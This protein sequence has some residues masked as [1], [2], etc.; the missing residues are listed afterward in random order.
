MADD[1]RIVWSLSNSYGIW[2]P[3]NLK[4]WSSDGFSTDQWNSGRATDVLIRPDGNLVIAADNGGI[5]LSSSSGVGTVCVSDSWEDSAFS[6]LA[7][8]PDGDQ[9]IFAG[10]DGAALY[11]TDLS[12]PLPL[13]D[14][15]LL[16]SLR[17]HKDVGNVY[18][19]VVLQR[20]RVIALA[21]DGGVFWSRI[22]APS[23]DAFDWRL[24]SVEEG[25]TG[26]FLSLAQGPPLPGTQPRP[27]AEGPI[28]ET[29]MAGGLGGPSP[30]GL[31]WGMWDK[32][33]LLVLRRSHLFN[34]GADVTLITAAVS[35]SVVASFAQNRQIGY[36]ACVQAGSDVL[37]AIFKTTDGGKDWLA[38]DPKM[39]GFDKKKLF[40]DAFGTTQNGHNL[41][42]AVSN[43]D[44]D[45][46]A[47]GFRNGALS[48]DGARHWRKPGFDPTGAT[49][50][51]DHL[52]ADLTNFA[53]WGATPSDPIAHQGY[54]VTSDGGVA[55]V[56]W[57]DGAWFLESDRREDGKHGNF[58]AVV[59]DGSNLVLH[60]RHSGG[61]D[62]LVWQAETTITTRASGAA[63][64]IQSSFQTGD[65]AN[66]NL[67]LVVPEDSDL[68]HYWCA[69][70]DG[71][72]S[73]WVRQ[74]VI[75]GLATGPGCLIQSSFGTGPHGNFEVVALE[76]TDLV[77]YW[78]DSA[79]TSSPWNRA[80]TITS[81]ASGPGCLIQSNFGT[82][83]DGN[84]EVVVQEG[85]NLVHYWHDSSSPGSP[86]NGPFPIH[87]SDSAGCFFQ[88][89]YP[90][91]TDHGNFELVFRQ[92]DAL[93]HSFR[94]NNSGG[95]P[96]SAT[97]TI[98]QPGNRASGPGCVFQSNYG[99]SDDHGNLELLVPESASLVHYFRD[100]GSGG[101]PWVRAITVVDAAFT[102]RSA[103]NQKLA[104]ME[105]YTPFG[106]STVVD[107]ALVG[108][109]QDNGIVNS[110]AGIAGS[111]W[112]KLEGGDGIAGFFLAGHS[113]KIPAPLAAGL[114]AVHE[115]NDLDA[116]LTSIQG[117]KSSH[118]QA[119]QLILDNHGKGGSVIPLDL[120]KP[121]S[122]A[123]PDPS[124]GLRRGAGAAFRYA[125]VR[126]PQNF[127]KSLILA[128]LAAQGNDLYVLLVGQDHGAPRRGATLDMHWEYQTTL[129]GATTIEAVASEDGLT[130]IAGLTE[131]G[132]SG[133]N[134]TLID[135][136][137]GTSSA[138]T[139]DPGAF[140][141]TVASI[142]IV[143]PGEAYAAV[144]GKSA[145]PILGT[146]G[147]LS[148]Q[149]LCWDGKQWAARG[150]PPI[151]KGEGG[152]V[153]LVVDPTR[154]P[155]TIFAATSSKVYISR[156]SSR[157]WTRA[158]KGL[159]QALLC[160]GLVWVGAS[161]ASQVYL[162]TY[163]RSIWGISTRETW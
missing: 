142:D 36:A 74:S 105:F 13:L 18:D 32:P 85:G 97:T 56:S 20:S 8:G 148:S 54:L 10:G 98:T 138:M 78:H 129:A 132:T 12:R 122:G 42:I 72:Y 130:A 66:G 84:L 150:Q 114:T 33:D 113:P 111:P 144:N 29:L 117:S 127:P 16:E 158:S 71:H 149:V 5:W 133:P 4:V 31:F 112:V 87:P 106:V 102:F 119:G 83:P 75:T 7:Q 40:S 64:L 34:Q 141:G 110:V 17:K 14:W 153:S 77:H 101:L 81:K 55:Q 134:L 47:L 35:R 139:V 86:W 124:L 131:T 109:L 120:P 118:W 58:Y 48:F 49:A 93:V 146:A 91:D 90:G 143:G 25:I 154:S 21:C 63:C 39:D 73:H 30:A 76:G 82:F 94:D 1:P 116:D 65:A 38:V 26:G 28:S 160:E 99:S 22:G 59:L 52:H 100:D 136:T 104:T 121:S 79:N 46:V 51:T 156:D 11:V 107:S 44:S 53:F 152:L 135:L 145:A 88:S 69:I 43:T 155:A 123:S 50:T 27:S 95:F 23:L 140:G 147:V 162:A 125:T 128:A 3:G 126:S 9:H 41:C 103:F 115:N 96:W 70:Y 151:A 159:P 2:M 68:V 92:G 61:A 6:T 62:A 163:G 15:I 24:A 161:V 57:G 108:P 60:V 67:E 45:I 80:L 137:T 89:D 37:L 19:I 157:T